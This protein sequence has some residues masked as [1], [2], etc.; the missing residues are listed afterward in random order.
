MMKKRAKHMKNSV[1]ENKFEW[2]KNKGTKNGRAI[3]TVGMAVLMAVTVIIAS[4]IID[5]KIEV[6]APETSESSREEISNE[7]SSSI[8]EESSESQF[9]ESSVPENDENSVPEEENSTS[10][11]EEI[12]NSKYIHLMGTKYPHLFGVND[13]QKYFL[14]EPEKQ[15]SSGSSGSS[16]SG[17][18]GSGSS[19]SKYPSGLR[20][21]VQKYQDTVNSDTIGWIYIPNTQINYPVVQYTDN[22]Y[23]LYRDYYKKYTNPKYYPPATIFA[24]YEVISDVST[25][26]SWNTVLYGHNWY[27]H[28]EPARLEYPKNSMFA[29]LSSY[30]YSSFAN[31]HRKI[32][33]STEYENLTFEVFAVFSAYTS[34]VDK[35]LIYPNAGKM[36]REYVVTEAL[37]RSEFD[38]GVDVSPDDKII[39]L[40]T[41]S[42]RYTKDGTGRYIVMGRLSEK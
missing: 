8:E 25:K 31:T 1:V 32:Y 23:Y 16:G 19:S 37:K 18:S 3:V 6:E 28:W 40:I 14:P 34:F 42:Y 9:E 22:E 13:E 7:L 26:M 15:E 10:E 33:Y 24:D 20:G 41:C 27:C 2:L 36:K 29:N 21:Y 30:R 35:Y 39:T 17:S 38:F 11:K 5:K 4:D 12:D